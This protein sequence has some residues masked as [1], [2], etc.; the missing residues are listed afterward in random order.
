MAEAHPMELHSL[1]VSAAGGPANFVCQHPY[2]LNMAGGGPPPGNLPMN[3]FPP[4][5]GVVNQGVAYQ[6]AGA[7]AV[8]MNQPFPQA[9][10][11]GY[12]FAGG[13][14]IGPPPQGAPT[15][16]AHANTTLQLTMGPGAPL[17]QINAVSVAPP[18]PQLA[19]HQLPFESVAPLGLH[20]EPLSLM[21]EAQPLEEAPVPHLAPLEAVPQPLP[22]GIMSLEEDFSDPPTPPPPRRKRPRPAA[23]GSSYLCG[24]RGNYVSYSPELR[25]EIGRYAAESGNLMAITHFKEKLGLEIPESTVRGLKEKYMIKRMRGEQDVKSLGFAQRGRPMRLGKYDAIV[26]DCIRELLKGGEKVSAEMATFFPPS[27]SSNTRIR[28]CLIPSLVNV[29][30]VD[31]D[32]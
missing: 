17:G 12:S 31:S 3:A 16:M 14:G 18:P 29:S 20:T 15:P 19:F 11:Q 25:A 28:C 1:N 13:N 24:K 21:K 32:H 22:D 7:P 26:Q 23:A 27:Q 2:S 9:F 8:I 30:R 4:Q 10:Q 6:Q 5:G